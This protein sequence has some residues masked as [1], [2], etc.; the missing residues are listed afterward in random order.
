[1]LIVHNLNEKL[2]ARVNTKWQPLSSPLLLQ[3]NDID[4]HNT[5]VGSTA[6]KERVSYLR[7]ACIT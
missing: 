7:D 1:M 4:I 2:D 3:L 6:S 5:T